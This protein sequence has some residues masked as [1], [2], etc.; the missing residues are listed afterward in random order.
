[1]DLKDR[2]E[3][4][5]ELMKTRGHKV[6]LE[7]QKE[8]S[9]ELFAFYN[10]LDLEDEWNRKK[11]ADLRMRMEIRKWILDDIENFWSDVVENEL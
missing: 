10:T 8:K 3:A 1:M 5:Q 9:D 11:I 7:I 6:L 4:L 2:R